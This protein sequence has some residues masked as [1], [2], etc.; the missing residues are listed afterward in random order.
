MIRIDSVKT[1][2]DIQRLLRFVLPLAVFFLLGYFY[3]GSKV[4]QDNT[5]CIIISTGSKLYINPL[6][7][8]EPMVLPTEQP[9]SG[10]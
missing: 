7:T 5:N 4:V 1:R 10:A 3:H 8:I 6:I 9:K 2:W